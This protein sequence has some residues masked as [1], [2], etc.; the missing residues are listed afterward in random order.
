MTSLEN[1]AR[2]LVTQIVELG[3]FNDEGEIS[4]KQVLHELLDVPFLHIC[5]LSLM[6][7]TNCYV[8][9]K[10]GRQVGIPGGW[11]ASEN[12]FAPGLVFDPMSFQRILS[13]LD[14]FS[15]Q[16]TQSQTGVLTLVAG[17]EDEEEQTF[18]TDLAAL[19]ARSSDGKNTY[20]AHFFCEMESMDLVNAYSIFDLSQLTKR[21]FETLDQLLQGRTYQDIAA[22]MD[23]TYKTLEKHVHAVYEMTGC[24]NQ[25]ALIAACKTV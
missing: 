22:K 4:D 1:V 23:I 12:L 2:K 21:Q 9:S 20:Y 14:R 6:T 8:N 7:K 19:V 10:F 17:D 3:C 15:Q 13:E 16:G 18:C 25:A 24:Q 5:M 11:I